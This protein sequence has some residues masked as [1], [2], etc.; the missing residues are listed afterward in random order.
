MTAEQVFSIVNLVAMAAW[1][2]LVFFP[3]VRWV[4]HVLPFALPFVFA[5]LYV[6]LLAATWG[7]S[8]GGFSSLAAVGA[9][10][11]DP[12]LLLAGWTHYLAFDL[13]VG[14]WELRD[15]QR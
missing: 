12:W 2:L 4:A 13:F 1:L 9:L 7:G 6:V 3:K 15:S 8:E 11:R 5:I 14:G 10:F